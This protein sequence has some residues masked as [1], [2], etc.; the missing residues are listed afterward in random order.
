MVTDREVLD[1]GPHLGNDPGALVSAQHRKPRHWYVAGDQVVVGVA[2]AGRFHLD[3]DFM[4]LGIADLDLLDRPRLVELPDERAFGLHLEPPLGLTVPRS[5]RQLG[6][7]DAVLEP[8]ATG[9]L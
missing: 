4:P 8:D 1:A 2:H 6:A 5:A 9:A 7:A 3:L